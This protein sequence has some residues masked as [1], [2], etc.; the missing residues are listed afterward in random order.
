MKFEIEEESFHFVTIVSQ[1]GHRVLM[2]QLRTGRLSVH[3]FQLNPRIDPCRSAEMSEELC[4]RLGI[5]AHLRMVERKSFNARGTLSLV[6]FEITTEVHVSAPFYW[7]NWDDAIDRFIKVCEVEIEMCRDLVVAGFFLNFLLIGSLSVDRCES[8]EWYALCY[9]KRIRPWIEK[10]VRDSGHSMTGSPTQLYFKTT[11]VIYRVPADQEFLYFKATSKGSKEAIRTKA[12]VEVF[13]EQT[14][15]LLQAYPQIEAILMRDFGATLTQLC[16]IGGRYVPGYGDLTS[17]YGSVLRQWARM[18]QKSV[19]HVNRLIAGGVPDY[20]AAWIRTGLNSLL[21]YLEDNQYLPAE[22]LAVLASC[23]SYLTET[24]G[25]WEASGIPR[26]LVHGDLHGGNI[27]QPKGLGSEYVI[28]D[29]DSAFIGYPFLDLQ[30]PRSCPVFAKQSAHLEYLKCWTHLANAPTI[31]KLVERT[32]P[33]VHLTMAIVDMQRGYL[34]VE[35]RVASVKGKVKQFLAG[36]VELQ[37]T[38]K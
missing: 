3:N 6:I 36:V 20:N 8:K 9:H 26:T 37:K 10:G 14:P 30:N 23:D 31:H 7:L 34:W 24:V 13:P 2:E 5:R 1:N 12:I 16:F 35:E 17:L 25:L 22:E 33:L 21:N 19:Q 15:K 4:S 38:K 28:F 18:Q 32:E 11:S 27:A 29:W